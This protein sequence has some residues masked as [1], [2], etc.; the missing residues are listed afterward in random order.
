MK[1]RRNQNDNPLFYASEIES[2]LTDSEVVFD[3]LNE[4]EKDLKNWIE[5]I[6]EET[7]LHLFSS[8]QGLSNGMEAHIHVIWDW[9]KELKGAASNFQAV[10]MISQEGDI[11]VI[12]SLANMTNYGQW[13]FNFE[14]ALKIIRHE[15][16]H[17]LQNRWIYEN[18]GPT[19]LVKVTE[20]CY[21]TRNYPIYEQNP[22]EW[23]A[24]SYERDQIH[25]QNVAEVFTPICER[26]CR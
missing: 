17:T 24:E 12:F 4:D 25:I 21:N 15:P 6:A 14:E 22:F 16:F 13:E 20:Y 18:Y 10:S 11:F 2:W 5:E 23:G 26:F 3:P 8:V 9:P 1:K 7:I 19:I